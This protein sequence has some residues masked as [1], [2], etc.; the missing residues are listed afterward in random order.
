MARECC[1]S[2]SCQHARMLSLPR[3]RVIVIVLVV[4]S[5]I[6]LAAL[7]TRFPRSP[8]LTA[9]LRV[10]RANTTTTPRSKF[11]RFSP[12]S[13]SPPARMSVKETVSQ[14]IATSHVVVFSK[15]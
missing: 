4:L 9:N 15:S 10:L 8:A 14:H 5:V 11:P 6:I 1:A 13:T 3:R 12:F 2:A 7:Y